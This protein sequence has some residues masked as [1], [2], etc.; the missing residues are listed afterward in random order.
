MNRA[1]AVLCVLAAVA[2]L[3][4]WLAHSYDDAIDRADTVEKTAADL[5]TQLKGAQGS[6]VT[7]TQYVDRVQTIRLKGD[8]IIKEIPRYVPIQADASCVVPRGFVRLHDA[9]AGAVPDPGAGDADAAPSGVALSTVAGTVADNY[10]DSHA[11]SA[12]LTDLQQLLRD[13][14]VTIIG[15]GVAP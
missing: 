13:Q 3:G 14:G 5:R 7:V 6:T 1:F 11:N 4:V 2:G 15:G 8:T 10:T 12:Q 9:A